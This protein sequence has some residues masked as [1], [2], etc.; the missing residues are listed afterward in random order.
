MTRP[1]DPIPGLPPAT[2]AWL[3]AYRAE[4][5]RWNRQISLV[6]R[7]E[8][9]RVADALLRQCVDAF[10]MWWES[11]G[12][13]LV[14][15]GS[16]RLFD[17]GS[18]G[19]L[20]AMAWLAMLAARGVD[21]EAVLVEPRA[22]RAWFL[23]RVG[24]LAGAPPFRVVAARWGEAGADR[25]QAAA[26]S[27]AGREAPIVFTLKALRLT[28]PAVLD[29]LATWFGAPGL[30]SGLP[31]EI[32][33]FQPAVRAAQAVLARELEIPAPASCFE[34]GGREF[35]ADESRLLLP[36]TAGPDAAGLLV[37]RHMTA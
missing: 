6:S 24:Q 30:P 33:R 35:R 13:Q 29:G 37:S 20:P 15:G 1:L 18:G 11:S 4:L 8:P 21:C 26:Q 25:A 10:E 34:A 27:G 17:L 7:R 3:A 16:L 32:V 23:E 2:A 5:L 36:G 14:A 12:A 9:E 28:E 31:V 22:K 19:G